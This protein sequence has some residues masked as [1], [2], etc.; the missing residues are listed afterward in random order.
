MKIYDISLP[1]KPDLPV[2]PG[3]PPVKLTRVESLSEGADANVSHIACGV[4]MGTHV[5]APLHFIDGS[6]A[7]GD[8][9][10]STLVG[11][12]HVLD[13]RG[14]DRIT[15]DLLE[16]MGITKRA[17]RLI[18]KTDN[19]RL[20]EEPR[21]DFYE[22]FVAVERDAAEWLVERRVQLVGIDYLS[23]APYQASI[24]T[25]QILLGA[26]VVVIEGLNLASVPPGRY[27][28]Y[29]LPIK[30]VDS[31]GAPARVILTGP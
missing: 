22:D 10:L 24:P 7:I 6:A 21:R 23:I 26:G 31:E 3:D 5:D 11:R 18:F 19:S 16:R 13:C 12:V 15:A 2:W 17:R 20:W 29:C 8:L 1:I 4:H 27:T 30:L 25:H 9:E 14:V 28:L